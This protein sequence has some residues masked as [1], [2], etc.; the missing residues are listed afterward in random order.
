MTP[1]VMQL[2]HDRVPL[3]L[4]IDLAALERPPSRAILLEE[5]ADVTWLQMPVPQGP[6]ISRTP[7]Q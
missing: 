2:L 1:S 5:P 4:L 6:S 7:A 3:T